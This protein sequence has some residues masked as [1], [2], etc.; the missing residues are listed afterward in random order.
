MGS[1]L[2]CF[3]LSCLLDAAPL[4]KAFL[5]IDTRDARKTQF[6]ST[7]HKVNQH[8]SPLLGRILPSHNQQFHQRNFSTPL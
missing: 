1:Y 2:H 5:G 7:S 4:Y 6:Y 8:T 3:V